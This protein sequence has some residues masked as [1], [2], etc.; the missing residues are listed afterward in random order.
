MLITSRNPEVKVHATVGSSDLSCMNEEDA[1][2]LLFRVAGDA[3]NPDTVVQESAKSIV[4][5][6]GGLPLAL[7]QAGAAIRQGRWTT[8]EF[9]ERYHRHQQSLQPDHNDNGTSYQTPYAKPYV[10]VLNILEI[11][12]QCIEQMGTEVSRDALDLLYFLSFVSSDIKAEELLERAWSNE[13][14]RARSSG[15]RNYQL[16][17]LCNPMNVKW[18]SSRLR[19]ALTILESYSLVRIER[20]GNNISSHP[21]IQR[22]VHDYLS[23]EELLRYSNVTASTLA[24]AAGTNLETEKFSFR[25]ALLSHLSCFLDSHNDDFANDIGLVDRAESLSS[26]STAFLGS[27]QYEKALELETRAMKLGER[28]LGGEH[29][30]TLRSMSRIGRHLHDLQ[31]PY[32]AAA[33]HKRVLQSRQVIL[34][35]EHY[36][37][38]ESIEFLASSYDMLN[39]R[40]EATT[41]M[42]K[43]LELRLK[44]FGEADHGTITTMSHLAAYYR[45]LGRHLEALKLEEK[46]LLRWQRH[47][48]EEHPDTLNSMNNLAVTYG[49]LGQEQKAAKLKEKVLA[50]NTRILGDQHPD[51]VTSMHNLAASY[52]KLGQHL[53]AVDLEMRVLEIKKEQLGGTHPDTLQAMA[54]LATTYETISRHQECL[55]LRQELMQ[56]SEALVGRDHPATLTL[57]ADLATSNENTGQYKHA[58]ELREKLLQLTETQFGRNHQATLKTMADLAT[59]YEITGSQEKAVELRESLQQINKNVW[60]DEQAQP[61]TDI[62]NVP[63]SLSTASDTENYSSDDGSTYSEGSTFSQASSDTSSGPV[64]ANAIERLA[65]TFENDLELVYAYKDLGVI[66]SRQKFIQGHMRLLKTYFTDLQPTTAEQRQAVSFI[67]SRRQRRLLAEKVY[68]RTSV[69]RRLVRAAQGTPDGLSRFNRLQLP[70]VGVMP[71]TEELE[72]EGIAHRDQSSDESEDSDKDSPKEPDEISASEV[73]GLKHSFTKG[74][75]YLQYKHGLQDFA[76]RQCSPGI[77]RSVMRHG[78][79]DAVRGVIQRHFDAVA[80]DEFEWLRELKSLGHTYHDMAELL[81]DDMNESPWIFLNQPQP[82]EVSIR[83][84]FHASNCVHQGGKRISLGPKLMMEDFE[85]AEDL[86]KLIA[87]HCGL[88]GVVPKSR[89]VNAWTGLVTFSGDRQSTASITYDFAWL[90]SQIGLTRM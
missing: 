36:E 31:R 60:E 18:Q 51:S 11:S 83:P 59:S 57:M 84:D 19:E 15:Y 67:R 62:R 56:Q 32:E 86:Q 25:E 80:A 39:Q 13:T 74:V 55:E 47:F 14:E 72:E 64:R 45:G 75:P 22:A 34:E 46:V 10:G 73:D 41:L 3:L 65:A 6:L 78:N 33:V 81:L 7:V 50:L 16:R 9:I 27:G 69:D 24:S 87:E 35:G 43:A 12:V 90:P 29:P 61:A 21:L 76:H 2:N 49:E 66:M 79:V 44:L 38:L 17:V 85:N 58:I 48:G 4:E 40:Q 82:Q 52:S 5:L 77:L 23:K 20:D 26:L 37:T 30:D 63:V 88:A 8:E 53:K 28:V 70:R 1:S 71:L 89:D 68:N 54:N 42:E